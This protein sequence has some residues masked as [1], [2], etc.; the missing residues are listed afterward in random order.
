MIAIQRQ[1]HLPQLSKIWP[2]PSAAAMAA[3]T[4]IPY[5]LPHSGSKKFSAD[6]F[7][8][9]DDFG[10]PHD[11]PAKSAS[12]SMDRPGIQQGAKRGSK[13]RN[14]TSPAEF[15]D[16]YRN[17]PEDLAKWCREGSVSDS[18]DFIKRKGHSS[19]TAQDRGDCRGKRGSRALVK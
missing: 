15:K 9:I 3:L 4:F 2:L 6:G 16:P 12:Q 5:T 13:V 8:S 7:R 14:R 1:L 10:Q 18:T 17:M 19:S 11:E